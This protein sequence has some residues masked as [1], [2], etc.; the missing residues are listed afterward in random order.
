MKFLQKA[1]PHIVAII[2]FATVSA[3]FF[4]PQYSGKALGQHDMVQYNGMGQEIAQHVDR[5]G[6]HPQWIGGAFSGMPAYL[7]NMNY[8]GRYVKNIADQSYFIGQPA[9]FLF[10]AMA[11]F[12]LMLLMFGV[13]PWLAI[14][15]GIGYGLS[16][17]FPIII[18]AGHITKMMALAWIP[19]LIG[20]IYYA[21]R[22]NM[23]LGA[24][25]VGIFAAVEI[26]T[27]HPQILYYFIFVI[28][29]LVINEFVRAYREKIIKKFLTT[30][31]V[32]LLAG[33]L[34]IGANA[35]QLYYIADHAGET[36]RG[37]SELSH[38]EA[39][40]V[41]T[42][43]L[44]KDYATQWSYGIGESFNMF[45]PRL[46]G[47][48]SSS[49]FSAE[50]E[51]AQSLKKYDAADIAPQLPSYWGDQLSTVGGVYIGAMF[52]FLFVLAMFVLRGTQKWWMF[53]AMV[54]ALLLAWGHNAMWL[55]DFF[56]DYVPLYNKFRTPSM[57][58][59]V[60]EFGIPLLAILALNK[61]FNEPNLDRKRVE[62]GLLWSVG[63]CG[64]FALFAALILPNFLSFVGGHDASMGLPE[65]VVSAMLSERASMLR[66]DAFRS[67][68]IVLI[69]G[70]VVY[71]TVVEKFKKTYA[72]IALVI[73]ATVDLFVVDKRFVKDEMFKPK[74]EA[75][76]ILPTDADK[77]ILKDT[78]N[79]RVANFTVSPF[80]DATTSFFHRSIGG[81][82]AAKLRRYQD[83][84]DAH[85]SKQNMAVYDMLNTKYFIMKEGVMLNDKALGNAW[86]VD[87]V[88][89][90]ANADEEINALGEGFV[91]NQVAVVD[92]KFEDMLQGI[93]FAKDNTSKIEL[94][95]YKVNE[96]TY[97]YSAPGEG[98][99]VFSEIYFSKGWT[100]TVDGVDSKY[101]RANYVLRAMV[102][103]AGEHT[104]V[105]K[106][107][108]PHFETL[109]N[110]TRICS[111]I[112]L[113]GT[114]FLIIFANVKCCKCGCKK[115]KND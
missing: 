67:L 46:M 79:Y 28:I 104:V 68:L 48:G 16:T 110:I 78:T 18:V 99:A 70:A 35:V 53:G 113:L 61:I 2:L 98:V 31:A 60:L 9:A 85:L 6:E 10:V 69:T 37:K 108:A 64:G 26:S 93:N 105:W 57:I 114:L 109:V 102:L 84:I 65:D 88:Q 59:V 111:L 54:L 1:L 34:A 107:K 96:L 38:T 91:P 50:G 90:V 52:V 63:I 94:V 25:L 15:G 49:G 72:V 22:K 41:S 103:P 106:F 55:T 43:G 71:F 44:D 80:Q 14:V 66:G 42:G 23:L 24:A 62:K 32:L 39:A 29:A 33:G 7:I 115:I 36:T 27:S 47:E 100:V 112:L 13:N 83:L 40:G 51:V 77:Q 82:H 92:R 87:S 30:S 74:K 73:V 4:A 20:S 76:A 21:Y 5:Y 101:F 81:Y 75:L 17:Y 45:I 11:T 56:L 58:L 8:D 19:A 97:T 12:Y 95:K 3:F 89:Y 86:F